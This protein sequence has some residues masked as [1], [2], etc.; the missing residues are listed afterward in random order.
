MTPT[1]LAL[2][3]TM[4]TVNGW[5]QLPDA[6]VRVFIII[7]VVYVSVLSYLQCMK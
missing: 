1:I 5:V 2:M 6:P 7:R 4:M 3:P